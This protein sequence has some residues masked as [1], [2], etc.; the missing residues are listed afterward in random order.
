MVFTVLLVEGGLAFGIAAALAGW[1]RRHFAPRP[2]AVT[3]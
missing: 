3:E 1:S 2:A